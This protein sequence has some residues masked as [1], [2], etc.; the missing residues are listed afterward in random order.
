M[1][2]VHIVT[3]KT[4]IVRNN[5]HFM[6]QQTLYETTNIVGD[7]EKHPM[8]KNSSFKAWGQVF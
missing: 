6:K 3:K 1:Q 2:R 7:R 4:N 8:M 5:K